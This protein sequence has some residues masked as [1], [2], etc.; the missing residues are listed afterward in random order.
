MTEFLLAA[1][2]FIL[3]AVA[4]GLVR[5]L[6]GPTNVD[7]T[8]AAQLLGTGGIAVLLLVAAATGARGAEDVALGLALLAAFT[9]VAFV[10]SASPSRDGD[11][12]Q[13]DR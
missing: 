2:G 4:V 9:S 12:E 1:A 11:Q 8:M 6:A 7:R 5:I 3:L 13:V 10:T